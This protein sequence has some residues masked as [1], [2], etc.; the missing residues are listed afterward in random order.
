MLTNNLLLYAKLAGVICTFIVKR[1]RLALT[2]RLHR[3][4]YRTSS[5]PD[6]NSGSGSSS[7]PDDPV[8]NI[9]IIGA[10]FAGYVAAYTLLATCLPRGYRV[11]II[12]KNSHF[13]FTWVFPRFSVLKGCGYESRALIPYGPFLAS[14]APEGLAWEWLRGRAVQ[15]GVEKEEEEQDGREEELEKKTRRRRGF[16]VVN[17]DHEQEAPDRDGENHVENKSTTTI[18][19][20]YLILATGSLSPTG[21]PS[22]LGVESKTAS[23]RAFRNLQDRIESAPNVVVL[24]GGPAGVE[25]AADTKNYYPEKNVTLVHSRDRLLNRFG[26]K[27]QKLAMEELERLGVRVVLRGRVQEQVDNEGY[28]VLAESGEKIACDFLV[29]IA[30]ANPLYLVLRNG[31]SAKRTDSSNLS[32]ADQM[33]RPNAQLHPSK[34]SLTILNHPI[35]THQSTSDAANRSRSR[36]RYRILRQHLRYW[37]RY[38]H[39][40]QKRP[41]GH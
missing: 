9:V 12:E 27:M 33:H 29:S 20:D 11:V 6:K 25:L 3:L 22:R 14:V 37:R 7:K 4:T 23:I 19:Y 28:I 8:R 35:R 1:L 40:R 39:R 5:I 34:E 36:S 31:S 24:G 41:L 16:V 17:D 2:A 13:Q 32:S 21:L 18:P 26:P 30:I 10:S 15:I 38:R